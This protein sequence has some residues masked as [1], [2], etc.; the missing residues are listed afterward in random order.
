VGFNLT[1]RGIPRK[2]YAIVDAEGHPIG[3]VTSGTQSPSLGQAIGLGYVSS[4][5]SA[6]GTRIFISIRGKS[7]EAE[8]TRIP[9]L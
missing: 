7:I 8:V 3:R 5:W 2:D 6:K 9:F 1:E 4:E